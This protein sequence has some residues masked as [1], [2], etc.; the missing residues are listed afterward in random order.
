MAKRV[1]RKRIKEKL[2]KYGKYTWRRIGSKSLIIIYYQCCYIESRIIIWYTFLCRIIG[3]I[4]TEIIEIKYLCLCWST[5]IDHDRTYWWRLER[6]SDC[7]LRYDCSLDIELICWNIPYSWSDKR[8]DDSGSLISWIYNSLSIHEC[9]NSF[10]ILTNDD[11]SSISI[12]IFENNKCTIQIGRITDLICRASCVKNKIFSDNYY[13]SFPWWPYPSEIARIIIWRLMN[14]EIKVI[15]RI[16]QVCIW[17]ISRNERDIFSYS[18]ENLGMIDRAKYISDLL[19]WKIIDSRSSNISDHSNFPDKIKIN[20]IKGDSCLT[21]SSW[22][23]WC[24]ICI[25]RNPSES[26][27]MAKSFDKTTC[28]IIVDSWSSINPWSRKCYPSS[29]L[30]PGKSSQR[31]NIIRIM[32][33]T[34]IAKDS[35]FLDTWVCMTESCPSY[36][37]KPETSRKISIWINTRSKSTIRSADI[38]WYYSRM[39]KWPCII[40]NKISSNTKII[41]QRKCIKNKKSAYTN[42]DDRKESFTIHKKSIG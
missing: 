14:K 39:T 35:W 9:I 7:I 33:Y 28:W 29:I 30:T 24:S 11:I 3:I 42:Q 22:Q 2:L 18:I 34:I 31:T 12:C 40:R 8:S 25:K 20:T 23:N 5:F 26:I 15:R 13:T 6:S 41:T 32:K 27:T 36:F 16:G 10:Y 38:K 17:N 19:I 37:P 4:C 1:K 21:C